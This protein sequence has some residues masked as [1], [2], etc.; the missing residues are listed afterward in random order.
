MEHGV[1]DSETS[2]PMTLHFAIC[3][4]SCPEI[5]FSKLPQGP[6]DGLITSF[7]AMTLISTIFTVITF[8]ACSCLWIHWLKQINITTSILKGTFCS[9]YL[10]L[11]DLPLEMIWILREHTQNK[12]WNWS[13]KATQTTLYGLAT[14][15]SSILTQA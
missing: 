10:I 1:I 5:V 15:P 8:H 7:L 3:K 13:L 14:L 11:R 12:T 4:F 2:M 9:G 6:S